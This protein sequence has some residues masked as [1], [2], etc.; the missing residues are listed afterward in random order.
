MV[1]TYTSALTALSLLQPA[2][3]ITG[4]FTYC[5]ALTTPLPLQLVIVITLMVFT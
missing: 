5:V 4:V 2:I 1:F 3:A